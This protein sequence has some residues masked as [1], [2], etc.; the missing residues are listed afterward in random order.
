MKALVVVD[1]QKDFCYPEG[2]LYVG[3]HV[4]KTIDNIR[5][6]LDIVRGSIPVIFT[7]DWHRKDDEEFNVWPKHC[8]QNTWGAEIVDE[9]NPSDEDYFVKKRRYSA[10]FGTD[11]DLLLRELDVDELIVCGV[12]TNICV[13]HTVAD[14]VMRGYKV[15]VLKDCTTALNEYDYEYG[16]K[17]MKD[18]LR[19]EIISSKDLRTSFE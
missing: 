15:T 5:D 6:V 17:H 7:Q 16:I 14:A 3:D 9:L 13:L 12:V 1:M 8:I 11:L 4:R 18:V 10:F 2:A 19:A